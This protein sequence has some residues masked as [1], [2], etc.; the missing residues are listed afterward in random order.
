MKNMAGIVIAMLALVSASAARDVYVDAINVNYGTVTGT[1]ATPQTPSGPLAGSWNNIT[2][3]TRGTGT[4]GDPYNNEWASPTRQSAVGTDL[5]TFNVTVR[6][7]GWGP[8][9]LGS[10][11]GPAGTLLEN[12]VINN[13]TARP[14]WGQ[15]AH[16]NWY[17]TCTG[18]P[19]AWTNSGFDV[20]ALNDG[21][22]V[23][24]GSKLA[25][26][27]AMDLPVAHLVV[28]KTAAI[29]FL[30]IGTLRLEGAV[31]LLQ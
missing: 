5:P 6:N 20:F 15:P 9:T 28:T 8:M 21:V 27:N 16:W 22:W 10:G 18:I 14:D 29:Q 24:I 7:G 31:L 3:I 23:Q 12:A 25:S 19:A 17:A 1:Q 30:R 13:S 4:D 11:G 2:N 26:T